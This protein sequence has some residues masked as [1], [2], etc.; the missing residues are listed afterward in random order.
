MVK[1]LTLKEEWLLDEPIGQGGFGKVYAASSDRYSDAVAKLIP[2][3]PGSEREMLFENLADVRNIVPIIDSGETEDSWVLVMPRAERSLRE[4]LE[5]P[6]GA[7]EAIAVLSDIA[8]ALSDLENSGV[9]HR[10][11]KPENVLLL[12][13][14]W[15]LADF[16]I[17]RYAEATTALDTHKYSMTP[18]YAAPEQWRSERATFATDVYALGVIAYELLAGFRPF[19][20]PAIH[21]YRSQHLHEEPPPLNG[22]S[23][24]V[25]ALVEE[26]LYKSPQTR[27]T[28]SNLCARLERASQAAPSGGLARLQ[29][30]NLAEVGRRGK[31]ALAAEQAR[32]KR[33]QREEAIQSARKALN[34]IT[35][36]LRNA[37]LE[38]APAA[39]LEMQSL[40]RRADGRA[41]QFGPDGWTVSLNEAELSYSFSPLALIERESERPDV[42]DVITF[43]QL[44]LRIPERAHSY[45]G[46]SHSLWFCDAQEAGRYQWLETAFMLSPYVRRYVPT[47]PFAL[48][49]IDARAILAL[50]PGTTEMQVAWPFTPITIDDLEEFIDRWAGWLAEGAGGQLT[51]PSA[52]PE[53]NPEGSWRRE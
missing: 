35:D 38:S 26:C 43:A 15:C 27:P 8:A 20:G 18:P 52:I 36:A 28:P 7:T 29:V 2:K 33:E 16:G 31:E 34:R 44:R 51:R 23:I 13:V 4:H 41:P 32:S 45:K 48:D 5:D 49:P 25:T 17:S 12:N 40:R 42:I 10:D 14:K 37:I 3:R 53:R 1:R 24:A 9:V 11:L 22:A 50:G 39:K 47:E 30:A 19:G 6:L 21:D 46:R